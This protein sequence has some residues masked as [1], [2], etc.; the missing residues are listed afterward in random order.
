MWELEYKESWSELKV[1]HCVW[2]FVTPW[3]MQSMKFSRPE[4]W[5]LS[6]LQGIFPT[7]ESNQCSLHCRWILYQL[8]YHQGTRLK[9]TTKN[10]CLWF[11]VLQKTL[12][13]LLDGKGIKLVHP[14][15][16][17]SWIFFG[18]TDT[19]AEISILWPPDVKNWLIGK[20]PD[21]GKDWKQEERGTIGIRWLDD[22]TDSM[23]TSLSELRELVM[24]REAWRAAVNGVAKSRMQLSD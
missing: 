16:N 1:T 10:W 11:V 2:L 22:I 7:Q 12:D 21:P 3:T 14:K 24:D 19:E 5:S 23:D 4:Y 17:Q 20:D 6:F 15:W 13:S 8:T 9:L 18:R